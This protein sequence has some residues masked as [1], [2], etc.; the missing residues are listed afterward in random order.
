M[1]IQFLFSQPLLFLP[2]ILAIIYGITVHEF[3]H[4]FMANRE[5]DNTAKVSGRLTLNPFAHLDL[6]GMLFLLFVGFG[7]G[8]PVPVN[9]YNLKRGKLSENLVSLAGIFTNL[10]S[11]VIFGVIFKIIFP[12]LNP[13]L[14]LYGYY[15]Q[16]NLLAYFLSLLMVLNI[17]LAVFN[18]IPVP[19]L[20]GS[21]VLFNILPDK[22]NNFKMQLAKNG[23]WV[24]LI[25][26]L[27]DNTLGIGVLSRIFNFF[28]DILYKIF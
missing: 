3:A 26:I 21:H 2:Y 23:P 17:V 6:F 18:L 8:K 20:D 4:A 10:V 19:P 9:N 7:W 16:F 22:Y 15:E 27:L 5:G 13:V 1:P 25:I 28:Y 14:M 11:V 24:L 12:E